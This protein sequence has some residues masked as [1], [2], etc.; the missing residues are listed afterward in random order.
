MNNFITLALKVTINKF[1][2]IYKQ[3]TTSRQ[4]MN[5]KN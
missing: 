1:Q 2:L 5:G 4:H 3:K